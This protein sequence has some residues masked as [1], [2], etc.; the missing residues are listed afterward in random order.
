MEMEL[1]LIKNLEK[2]NKLINHKYADL[3]RRYGDQF[4]ALDNGKVIAHDQK[5]EALRKSLEDKGLAL[6]TVI[7][8]YI[9]KKGVMV[10]Y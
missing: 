6:A 2:S 10:L 7:I 4:I 3:Q 8:E 5:V 9:P 1:Q